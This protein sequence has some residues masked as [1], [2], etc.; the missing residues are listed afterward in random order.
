[1][2]LFRRH[3]PEKLQREGSGDGGRVAFS[4]AKPYTAP[5]AP[6]ISRSHVSYQADIQLCTLYVPCSAEVE[7]VR[8]RQKGYEEP[9]SEHCDEARAVN[10]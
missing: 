2:S 7:S 8:T 9:N 3:R 4:A 6:S 5:Q 1:M 10:Y